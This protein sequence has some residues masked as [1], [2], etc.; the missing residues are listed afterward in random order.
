MHNY[1]Y[2]QVNGRKTNISEK[3]WLS[4][5]CTSLKTQFLFVLNNFE[6]EVMG[7]MLVSGG[8]FMDVTF[9]KQDRVLL[10]ADWH[11]TKCTLLK[12][13]FIF[14]THSDF[15]KVRERCPGLYLCTN[16]V[17]STIKCL[18]IDKGVRLQ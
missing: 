5:K 12:R 13:C 16:N 10:L 17:Y 9:R 6:I 2:I 8:S 11:A 7:L 14:N 4:T 1:L 15:V 3:Q 18:F